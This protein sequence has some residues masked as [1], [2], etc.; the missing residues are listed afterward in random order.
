MEVRP[1]QPE[2]IFLIAPPFIAVRCERSTVVK[3]IQPLKAEYNPSS[4]IVVR[5]ERSMEVISEE[6]KAAYSP[7]SPTVVSFDKSISPVR[8]GH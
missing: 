1:V 3:D 2:H 7:L 8:A 5:L 4:A 6:V